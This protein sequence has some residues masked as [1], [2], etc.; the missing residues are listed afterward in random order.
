MKARDRRAAVSVSPVRPRLRPG[1]DGGPRTGGGAFLTAL[2]LVRERFGP[3]VDDFDPAPAV[4]RA[5]DPFGRR[6]R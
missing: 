1:V 3:G 5:H 4:I 6:R 2:A